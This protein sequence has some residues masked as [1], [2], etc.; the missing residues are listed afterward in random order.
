MREKFIPL[1]N[2]SVPL[3]P[4]EKMWVNLK[5]RIC[6]RELQEKTLGWDFSADTSFA[7][8]VPNGKM[9]KFTAKLSPLHSYGKFVTPVPCGRPG[10]HVG[11]SRPIRS[12]RDLFFVYSGRFFPGLF[13]N[14]PLPGILVFYYPYDLILFIKYSKLLYF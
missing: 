3:V 13:R 7:L 12:E 6:R 4:L 9:C 1:P 11:L 14:S 8:R 5:L 2:D 10:C